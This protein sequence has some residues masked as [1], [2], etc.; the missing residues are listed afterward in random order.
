MA[1]SLIDLIIGMEFDSLLKEHMEIFMICTG[2]DPENTI[3]NSLQSD[4]WFK[5]F[6]K[7]KDFLLVAICD[8][9]L[10]DNAIVVLHNFMT[11]PNLKFQVYEECKSSL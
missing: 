11:S 1:N 10:V 3:N 9:E 8:E 5:F 7:F 2:E 4:Q 6:Q